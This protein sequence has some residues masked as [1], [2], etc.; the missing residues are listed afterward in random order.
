M[1][2]KYRGY[3][4]VS[5]DG[6]ISPQDGKKEWNAKKKKKIFENFGY[7]ESSR[8][9]WLIATFRLCSSLLFQFPIHII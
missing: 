4:I 6:K 2:K 8:G 1:D 3:K 7:S 5:G 9:G